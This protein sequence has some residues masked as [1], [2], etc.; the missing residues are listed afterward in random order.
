MTFGAE[1]DQGNIRST[2]F[3]RDDNDAQSIRTFLYLQQRIINQSSTGPT[4]KDL[5]LIRD[6]I[7]K[8]KFICQGK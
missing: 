2:S 4:A 7:A 5:M 8:L 1:S 6:G 3:P